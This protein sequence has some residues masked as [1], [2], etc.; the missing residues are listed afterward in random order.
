MDTPSTPEQ[1]VSTRGELE[2]M[3]SAAARLRTGAD[4]LGDPEIMGAVAT[5]ETELAGFQRWLESFE[6]EF[7]S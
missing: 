1:I 5:V 6:A 2:E 3:E 7:G 4:R